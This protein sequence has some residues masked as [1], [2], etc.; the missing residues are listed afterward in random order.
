MANN[1]II[2]KLK[3]HLRELFQFDSSDLDFGIYRIMNYKRKE[4]ETFIEQDLIKAVQKE[5]ERYK[6]LN[7]KELLEKIDEKK[8]EI[9]KL[10]KELGEKILKNGEIEEKFKDK[11]FA[12]EYLELKKQLEE[13]ELTENIQTQVF[14]D[15]YNFFSRYYEDG[16]FISKKRYS[17]KHYK[18]AIPYSG[19]EVK[20]HWAN[21]DQYYVKTGEIFKN[22]EFDQK[23]HRFIFR[24]SIV[25]VPV[26]NVKGDRRYFVLQEDKPVQ[27]EN[28]T[29]TINFEYRPLTDNDL[30]KYPVE[31]K[32]GKVKETG[33][34]QD[35]LNP[36]LKDKILSAIKS[37]EPKTI[38]SE[39]QDNKTLLEKHLLKFTR[40]ITSDF[41]IHKDLKGFLEREL[42]YF[43][44]TEVF[45]I[46]T[47][48]T[49]KEKYLAKHLT[50]TKVVRNIGRKII[51]FLSQIENFQKYLW[52]K[53]K[54]VLKT[55][56][57]ITIDRIPEDFH[58]EILENKQQL[59]EWEELGFGQIKTKKDI[60]AKKLPVD[61][62]YFSEDF[63]ERLLEQIGENGNIDDLLDGVLIKSENW[64][65]LNLLLE[66]YKE[67]VQ[68]IYID[69]PFNTGRDFL[70]KDNYRDSSWITLMFNRAEIAKKILIDKGSIYIHLNEECNYFLREIMNEIFGNH[71]FINELIW[72]YR[73]GGAPAKK[74]GY[75]H[76]HDTILLFSKNID[77]FDAGFNKLKERIYYEKS[78]FTTQQDEEGRY[79]AEVIL[80]DVIG[81]E[82]LVKMDDVLVKIS[83]KPVLNVSKECFHF[84]TQKPEGLVEILLASCSNPGDYVLDYFLG[85]GTT[86][87]VA[88]KL[89]R[90]WI[91]IEMGDFF[92]EFYYDKGEKK[93]GVLGRMKEVLNGKGNH[94][95]CG[96]SKEINWQGGGFFKYQYL[97]QYEDT[98]HNIDFPEEQRAQR[99][100]K[101]FD[102]NAKTE[103]LMK[104]LLKFE[105]EGSPSILDIKQFENPFEYKL[106]IISSGKGEESV[107][108]DLV[109]TFNYLIGLKI[110]KYRFLK[111]NGR[112][113][114]FV[115][116]ERNNRRTVIVWRPTKDINLAKDKET[117]DS[118]L[119]GYKP[120]EIFVNGDSFV[121]GAKVLESEFKALMG[122]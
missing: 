87:A 38:L 2:E 93:T 57:V 39:T 113:Y 84:D 16:D 70:Y 91:G 20:L 68:T 115:L 69:P 59:K 41:F 86:V 56:Y 109:E 82:V 11:P 103:Y 14:N 65:A 34:K 15:L 83:C 42:D 26:G 74:G 71:N 107:K 45:D 35:K 37:I 114:V 112:K 28:K 49:E 46:E 8:K 18:Y 10:E 7:Q 120:D 89:G 95:P 52:E 33:I 12:K 98:L 43:I 100:L 22:Y 116:G 47:L 63:K 6:A 92:K 55:N 48:D 5:F 25:D 58:K 9:L 66:K 77:K 119:N 99:M 110:N 4:I 67:R 54:F 72:E 61:T 30:K 88:H 73:T 94:E 17:G 60:N 40:K 101:F 76:K 1:E 36:I 79:Y 75:A 85:I 97:E 29:C 106:K 50:R 80:R 21:Y 24:T 53:K 81:G 117:I 13:I 51:E 121:K 118:V 31:T 32:D 90:K 96:I 104:Y 105:T 62:K 108:V 111:E 27:I 102:D 122:V 64:Q 23:G 3:T 78:F 44:K 19:E